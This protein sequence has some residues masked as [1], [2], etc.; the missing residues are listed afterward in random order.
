MLPDIHRER[1]RLADTNSNEKELLTNPPYG[2]S[3]CH[4]MQQRFRLPRFIE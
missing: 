1:A 4:K 3:V 2:E